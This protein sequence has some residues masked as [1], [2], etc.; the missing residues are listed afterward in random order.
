MFGTSTFC[1]KIDNEFEC[2]EASHVLLFVYE[3]EIVPQEHVLDNVVSFA[4]C[5]SS[6]SK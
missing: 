6:V 4:E 3:Q 2:H 5:G 1:I